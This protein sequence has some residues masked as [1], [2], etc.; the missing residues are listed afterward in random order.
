MFFPYNDHVHQ[1]KCINWAIINNYMYEDVKLKTG[2]F[3]EQRMKIDV[4][5]F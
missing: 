3:G 1:V 5:R 4:N 2:K